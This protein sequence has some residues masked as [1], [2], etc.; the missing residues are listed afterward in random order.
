MIVD[1]YT[2]GTGAK[3]T[4]DLRV[5]AGRLSSAHARTFDILRRITEN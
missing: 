1:A 4:L 3:T 5:V 2:L